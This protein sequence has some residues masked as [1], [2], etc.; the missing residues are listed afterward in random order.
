VTRLVSRRP[1]KDPEVE[2]A[3]QVVARAHDDLAMNP[4]LTRQVI[5]I[6]LPNA[7]TVKTKHK[8]GRKY[9]AYSLT[10]PRGATT[11]GRI[12]DIEPTDG[13]DDIWLQANGYGATVTVRMT[14][15]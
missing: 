2:R 9:E 12:V 1:I 4:I 8:L 7:T 5:T 11:S 6:T 14:V 13:T 10:A 15:Y 3:V